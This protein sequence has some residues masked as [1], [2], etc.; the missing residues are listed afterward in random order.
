MKKILL[1]AIPLMLITIVSTKVFSQD[2]IVQTTTR[3]VYSRWERKNLNLRIGPEVGF[4][5]GDFSTTH[6]IGIGASAL[7]D[8]PVAR[9]WSVIA[10]AGMRSFG[11]RTMPDTHTKYKRSN[12][13]PL[14]GGI[15][16]KLSPDFYLSGQIGES[17]VQYL[18]VSK[19]SVSQAVG[20]GYFN[21]FLDLGV[22]WDHE[23]AHGGLS[24]IVFQARYV[25]T[26]GVRKK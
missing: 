6:H 12:I 19:T 1:S 26:L 11:G 9:R 5:V 3:V 10:Y 21:G 7:L 16:Y 13:F 4:A 18:G 24:S 2:T 14:R 20:F 17:T 23:Y 8:I 25:I 15:N 22:R